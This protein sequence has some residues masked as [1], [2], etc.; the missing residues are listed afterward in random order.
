MRFDAGQAIL[1]PHH[2][3]VRVEGTTQ[4]PFPGSRVSYLDLTALEQR[5]AIALP[6]DKAADVGLREVACREQATLWL[7]LLEAPP[8]AEEANSAAHRIKEYGQRLSSRRVEDLCFLIRADQRIRGEV[9]SLGRRADA[10]PSP[11]PP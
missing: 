8:Q 4:R 3:P 1:H 7:A 10:A 6:V 11:P 2:G 5:L 9:T